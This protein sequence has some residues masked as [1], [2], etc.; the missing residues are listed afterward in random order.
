MWIQRVISFY[1]V[2]E[3]VEVKIR[4]GPSGDLEGYLAVLEQLRDAMDHFQQFNSNSMELDNLNELFLSGMEALIREFRQL[5]QKHSKPV[6]VATLT[7]IAMC[8]DMEG[9][10]RYI[11]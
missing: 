10:C 2:S 4:E 9:T 5:L 1:Q 8:E 7:D 6:H 11:L 3:D